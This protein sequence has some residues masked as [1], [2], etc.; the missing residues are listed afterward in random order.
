MLSLGNSDSVR[1]NKII[2]ITV[3]QYETSTTVD[4][5][6]HIW[7][8]VKFYPENRKLPDT[9]LFSSNHDIYDAVKE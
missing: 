1:S 2:Y 7:A 6:S 5:E 4:V 8:T 3:K 9:S